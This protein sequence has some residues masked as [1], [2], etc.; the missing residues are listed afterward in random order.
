MPIGLSLLVLLSIFLLFRFG[1]SIC[2]SLQLSHAALLSFCAAWIVSSFVPALMITSVIGVNIALLGV[3][4]FFMFYVLFRTD[5]FR[6][7]AR[8]IS[9]GLVTGALLLCLTYLVPPQ[10]QGYIY[11][12]YLLYGII[13]GVLAFVLSRNTTGVAVSAVMGI[14]LLDTS[15]IMLGSNGNAVTVLA[16]T[17]TLNALMVALFVGCTP[18]VLFAYFKNKRTKLMRVPLRSR[19]K[20]NYEMAEDMQLRIT[21]LKEKKEKEDETSSLD[22]KIK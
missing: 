13:G 2:E 20:Y 1:D 11:Q 4:L 10:P 9:A 3:S 14:L 21:T 7:A 12:P 6:F 8:T 5:T 17:A 15:I 16:G 19:P 22:T 18:A